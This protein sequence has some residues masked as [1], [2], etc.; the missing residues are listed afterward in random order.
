MR[1]ETVGGFETR[2]QRSGFWDIRL[3]RTLVYGEGVGF[4][5]QSYGVWSTRE[6]LG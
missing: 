2:V 3:K 5:S 4:S 1:V 6:T